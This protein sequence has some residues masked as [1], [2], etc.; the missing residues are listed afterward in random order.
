MRCHPA[1]DVLAR[2]CKCCLPSSFKLRMH[3]WKQFCREMGGQRISFFYSFVFIR[4]IKRPAADVG[5]DPW[6]SDRQPETDRSRDR[7]SRDEAESQVDSLP[8]R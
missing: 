5:L 2:A 8:V 6:K 3:R 1:V 7:R 4:E